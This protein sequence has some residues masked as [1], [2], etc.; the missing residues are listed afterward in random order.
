MQKKTTCKKSI[1]NVCVY[2]GIA[3][4]VEVNEIFSKTGEGK[5]RE[6]EK[7][8]NY[9]H[10]IRISSNPIGTHILLV[11]LEEFIIDEPNC[12]FFLYMHN[13]TNRTGC[14][15]VCVFVLRTVCSSICNTKCQLTP[16][17]LRYL[18]DIAY[19]YRVRQIY[20]FTVLER[21]ENNGD[22]TDRI[23]CF[24]AFYSMDVCVSQC[25]G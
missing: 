20:G 10:S 1:K 9:E 22:A 18:C 11:Q 3:Y 15:C 4:E 14:M 12:E 21:K 8:F 23:D 6:R 5:E 2:S 25:F 19:L 17:P 13:T 7:L 16:T 24:V